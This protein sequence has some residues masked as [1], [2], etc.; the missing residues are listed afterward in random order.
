[1]EEVLITWVV[2]FIIDGLFILYRREGFIEMIEENK[3]IY[4]FKFTLYIALIGVFIFS[5]LMLFFCIV[6]EL[7]MSLV[8]LIKEFFKID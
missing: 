6:P 8:D 4:S 3:S 5:P 7:V 1:M 2:C